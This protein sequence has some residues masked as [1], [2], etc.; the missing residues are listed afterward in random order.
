MA[1]EPMKIIQNEECDICDNI[2]EVVVFD[3]DMSESQI[4]HDCLIEIYRES[5]GF[6]VE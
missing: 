5:Q 1:D 3:W 6:G 4:C 2:G